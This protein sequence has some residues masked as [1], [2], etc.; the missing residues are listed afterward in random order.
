MKRIL[1]SI[2]VI[3]ILLLSACGAPTY[4]LS[5]SV[6]PLGT[7][8]VSPSGGQYESGVQ[9]TLTATPAS[10]YAFDCWGGD[11]SGSSAV[12]M[13]TMDSD[14][15]VIANFTQIT[16]DLTIDIVG[17]GTTSPPAGVH[18]YP[19]GTEV[20]LTGTP[21]EGWEFSSWSGDITDTSATVTIVMDLDKSVIAH[22]A[23]TTPP[24]ISGVDISRI[25]E[26]SATIK[27]ETDELANSQVEYGTTDAYG[28]TTPLDEGLTTSHS[29]TLTELKPE[30]T[31]HFRVK[32]ADE[33]GNEALSDDY[34]FTTKTTKE[35]LSP[36]LYSGITIGGRVHQLSF[37]L[38]NGSSQTITVTKVEIF[39]EH[40]DVAFTMSK[41]DI[42]ET[43]GSGEVD[44]GK[45]LSAGISFGIPPSTT[46][47]EDWQ[48]KWYCLDANGVK[49][50]VE[51]KYSSL[52]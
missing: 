6:S 14:K 29:V 47:V 43:W 44:V 12:I 33:A 41:S 11:V 40:G 8:S 39:D 49:F 18:S 46:E 42:A 21:D 7:G 52:P 4:T 19:S 23:D 24:V 5:T 31:Y 37:N 26:L 27:W 25:T 13:I 16:Y 3:G 15:N 35:L 32:S 36:M 1:L 48:V 22:F 28:S 34:T 51:G 50:T 2:V 10:G 45:S 30:T 17:N 38:F 20:E 9:V